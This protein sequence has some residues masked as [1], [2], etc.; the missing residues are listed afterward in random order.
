MK[1]VRLAE[2]RYGLHP[3]D[4]PPTVNLGLRSHVSV[5]R[6]HVRIAKRV[7]Q[8][9]IHHICD[10]KNLLIYI[11]NIYFQEHVLRFAS[12]ELKHGGSMKSAPTRLPSPSPDGNAAPPGGVRD[13][14]FHTR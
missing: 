11:R 13:Y 9:R 12:W 2:N 6:E 7:R 3:V 10:L 4:D 14:I 8:T 1:H 5:V